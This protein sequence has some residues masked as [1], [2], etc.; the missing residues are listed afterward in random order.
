MLSLHIGL[1]D[2][3]IGRPIRATSSKRSSTNTIEGSDRF[4]GDRIVAPSFAEVN[5]RRLTIV[6][7]MRA[8]S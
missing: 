2:T 1:E 5:H 4:N 8:V 7:R 3:R 6:V